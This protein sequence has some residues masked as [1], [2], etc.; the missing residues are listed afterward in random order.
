MRLRCRAAGTCNSGVGTVT[1]GQL[2]MHEHR[3]FLP[4]QRGKGD[5]TCSARSAPEA[6]STTM[7]YCRLWSYGARFS[8]MLATSP[9]LGGRE[10][11]AD[12]EQVA[13][14]T[15]AAPNPHLLTSCGVP[16]QAWHALQAALQSTGLSA[17]Q[18]T[19]PNSPGNLA[20]RPSPPSQL[21]GAAQ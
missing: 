13:R 6:G 14:A 3:I 15:A 20:M 1:L 18:H 21:K 11:G 12:R 2:P 10:S 9:N 16:A 5:P 19:C 8:V 7:A 17:L 4:E